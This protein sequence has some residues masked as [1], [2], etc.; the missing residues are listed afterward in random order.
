MA[1]QVIYDVA[2]LSSVWVIANIYESD[3]QYIKVGQN[4]EITSTSYPNEPFNAKINFVDPVFDPASRTLEVRIDVA[5]RGFK[6]KPDMYVKIKI[7]TFR[8]Q[9]L[10]VPKNAVIRT[11]DKDIV[12][13][14]KEKGVYVPRRVKIGYE[15][16]GYYEILS[17]L[18]EGEVVVSSGGFLI[19][20]ES[21]IE[22]GYNSGHSDSSM[23]MSGS[24]E[25]FKINPDRD[26]MKDMSK[27]NE[28]H[29]H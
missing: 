29:Q 1:G 11:G 25:H 27:K 23:N 21:Q 20:S 26:I 19:D 6:L 9:N 4:V 12:Y 28:Q 8:G 24:E 3:V 13:V 5:N 15:Q 7:N 22:L 17:G 10:A 16:D 14:E 2:N 18:K